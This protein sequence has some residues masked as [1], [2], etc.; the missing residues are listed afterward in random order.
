MLFKGEKKLKLLLILL[1]FI[2]K[3]LYAQVLEV[4][5]SDQ[6]KKELIM[7]CSA[8]DKLC[9]SLCS[10]SSACTIQEGPCR[11]CIGT[12]VTMNFF[13]SELGHLIQRSGNPL[14]SYVLFDLIKGKDWATLTYDD[15]YNIIDPIQS[16]KVMKRFEALCPIESI[17]QIVFLRLNPKSR[18]IKRAEIVYCN[19]WDHVE[20]YSLTSRPM[21]DIQG[22]D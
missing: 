6:F 11:D 10:A 9:E 4:Q 20:I 2:V 22:R 15:V 7:T 21:I 1:F 8:E 19:L 3:A 14:S 18:E 12:S 13:I 16:I 5:W 17:S